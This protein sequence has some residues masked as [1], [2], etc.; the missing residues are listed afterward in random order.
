MAKNN[1]RSFR[2]S[3]EVA[4]ILNGFEGA[5][6]NE[7]FEKLVLYCARAVPEKQKRLNEM[8]RQLAAKRDELDKLKTKVSCVYDIMIKLETVKQRVDDV[9]LEAQKG[10][11]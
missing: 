1:I 5:N 7:K 2:Y 9:W 3:D 8:D 11:M 6:M 10:T 4:K